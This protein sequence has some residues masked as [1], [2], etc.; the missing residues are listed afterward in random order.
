MSLTGSIL[1]IYPF[2]FKPSAP[3]V[4]SYLLYMKTDNTIYLQDSTGSEFAFGS[5]TAISQLTG[6]GTAIGP[7]SAVLTLS[8]AA[9]I[10]K[11]LTGF[12]AGPNST[13]LAT[14]TVLEAFEKLQAQVS[15]SS[16]SAITSLTGD[17]SATGP[18][19]AA[20]TVNSVGGSSAANINSA[21]VAANAATA[22]NTASTIVKRD[23]SGNF[24]ANQI[25]A[26]LTGNV[27]GTASN[28]TGVVVVANGGTGSSS[29]LSNNRIMRSSGGL[30]IEAAAITA[31]RALVSNASGIPTHSVTTDTELSYVSGVTSAIQTQL[32]SISGSAITA[33][34]GDVVATGPGSVTA[35]I[36]PGAIDNSKVSATAAIAY[37]KL[38]LTGSIVNADVAAAA[39]ISLTKLAALTGNKALQSDG[40]GVISEAAVT[41]TE[42]GYVSGVTSAIQ[43]QLNNKQPLDSDLTA[44]A[45]LATT[46]LIV[47]TGTGTATTRTLTAGTGI[48][49]SDGD[50]VA[51]NPVITS[52][53]SASFTTDDLPEGVTNK[54]FTDERAQD[55]VGNIL[56]DTTTIDLTYNDAG[57]TISADIQPLSITNSLISASAAIAYSK[58]NLTGSIVNAD[59][60]A[61]AA[62][63]YSKLS[64]SNSIVNADINTAAA[65]A[66]SKLNLTGSIVNADVATGAAIAYSKLNLTGSIVNADVNAAAAIAY[67]KLLLTNSIVNADINAS[68]AIVYSKLAALTASRA[69]QSDGSGFVSVSAVT[70]TEL[71]YVSGVTSAIQTQ[72]NTKVNRAGDTM[73]GAFIESVVVL[74]DA[75]TIAVDA[76]LGNVYTVTLGGNRTLG[77]PTNPTNG[78]KIVIRVRQDAT[79]SRTLAF[80]AIYRFG[81]DITSFTASTGANKTDYLGFMYNGTDSKW[82]LVAV[83]KGF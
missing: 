48:S 4:G 14:D 2:D 9:V 31:N 76:S 34:T 28:V 29:A 20:A 55:A 17:V 77:A 71:G 83:S 21:E 62:I 43:T 1:Q 13:V 30:I 57:N 35:T 18:G 47:R 63:V 72:I 73:T 53:L 8:N 39:A 41:S 65:I 50:G 52:T 67:S 49:I 37:S 46:G 3:P 40:S 19:A 23:A 60:N 27:S 79:G 45:A 10:G 16:G 70:N 6:E 32:N 42:L 26:N 38:N 66:Y 11:V 54:Y 69:L 56:T 59:I 81:I 80:N 82:D 36:Q 74:T 24:S 12:V 68:A 25:T 75:A 44:L 61:A 5:T 33:L 7:G 15:A 64:L 51:G 78:Q 58:L 22:A